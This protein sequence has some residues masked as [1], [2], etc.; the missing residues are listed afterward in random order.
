MLNN[1]TRALICLFI[2]LRS[3][4]LIRRQ[5]WIENKTVKKIKS[6][7]KMMSW[8]CCRVN[9]MEGSAKERGLIL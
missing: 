1:K 4:T 3:R 7:W 2:G 6:E 5:D 9:E 8:E